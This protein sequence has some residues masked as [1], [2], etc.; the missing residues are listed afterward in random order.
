MVCISRGAGY[1][2]QDIYI[3]ILFGNCL[4]I[5]LHDA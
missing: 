1:D 4:E 3:H 5:D 2:L